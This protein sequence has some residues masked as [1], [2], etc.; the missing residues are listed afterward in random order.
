M[1]NKMIQDLIKLVGTAIT[2]YTVYKI[3]PV[4]MAVISLATP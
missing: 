4:I 1:A 3:I 2:A